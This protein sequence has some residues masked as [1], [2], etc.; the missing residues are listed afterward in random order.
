[1]IVSE[2]FDYQADVVPPRVTDESYLDDSDLYGMGFISEEKLFDPCYYDDQEETDNG[3]IAERDR[4]LINKINK[5]NFDSEFLSKDEMFKLI[6]LVKLGVKAKARLDKLEDLDSEEK[7]FLEQAIL[8]GTEAKLKI[9]NTHLRFAVWF[10]K[11]TMGFHKKSNIL[12]GK[13]SSRSRFGGYFHYNFAGANLSFE[14]RFQEV[15]TAMWQ[16]IDK[17]DP[18]KSGFLNFALQHME[19]SLRRAINESSEDYVSRLPHKVNDEFRRIKGMHRVAEEHGELLNLEDV[20]Y[21]LGFSKFKVLD[22]ADRLTSMSNISLEEIAE[23]LDEISEESDL[24]QEDGLSFADRIRQPDDQ[25]LSTYLENNLMLSSLYELIESSL[26]NRGKQIVEQR[27]GVEGIDP[28]TLREIG[29][30]FDLSPE[31]IRQILS[32]KLAVIRCELAKKGLDYLSDQSIITPEHNGDIHSG[33]RDSV[34]IISDH[35]IEKIGLTGMIKFSRSPS[36]KY[37]S[38]PVYKRRKVYTDDW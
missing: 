8:E 25:G 38:R 26:D 35:E 34:I 18:S 3:V 6:P 29:D 16:C 17:Y 23:N 27:F 2:F 1:M 22:L 9:F 5:E 15:T 33:I 13:A 36:E 11:E 28:R 31:R 21:E 7:E 14:D 10:T 19:S 12:N 4:I 30:D 24:D 20:M 37:K 32:K